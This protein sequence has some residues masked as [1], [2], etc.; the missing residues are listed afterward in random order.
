MT[1][2]LAEK[3]RTVPISG[4]MKIYIC[5]WDAVDAFCKFLL[6]PYIIIITKSND[7]LH[8]TAGNVTTAKV[9]HEG[10]GLLERLHIRYVHGPMVDSLPIGVDIISTDNDRISDGAVSACGPIAA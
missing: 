3:K 6:L 10:A 8:V 2:R 4:K 1:I 7:F 9:P 5:K